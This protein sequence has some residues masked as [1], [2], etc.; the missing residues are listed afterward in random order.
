M[1]DRYDVEK[2]IEGIETACS[3]LSKTGC[4]LL[5][6]RSDTS[7]IDECLDGL[8]EAERILK[9]KRPKE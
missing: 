1:V 6:L 2:A 7:V 3:M 9:S 8:K 5:V 4:I